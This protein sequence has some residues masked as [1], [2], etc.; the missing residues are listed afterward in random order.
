TTAPVQAQ[1]QEVAQPVLVL[2][3][4]I[5]AGLQATVP[6]KPGTAIPGALAATGTPTARSAADVP[7]GVMPLAGLDR[8]PAAA[9]GADITLPA[10]A[11]DASGTPLAP[12]AP[13][14]GQTLAAAHAAVAASNAKLLNVATPPAA[15]A[16]AEPATPAPEAPAVATPH[17]AAQPLPLPIAS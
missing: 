17:P 12:K 7:A 1:A 5:P 4:A 11:T 13:T 10:D 16:D 9:H 15:I 2:N 8:L 3:A 14:A 6:D